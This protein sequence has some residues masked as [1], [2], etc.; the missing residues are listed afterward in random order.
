MTDTSTQGNLATTQRDR[1]MGEQA[2]M[3]AMHTRRLQCQESLEF[4]MTKIEKTYWGKYEEYLGIV[5]RSLM[6]PMPRNPLP[7]ETISESRRQLKM[8]L[9]GEFMKMMDAARTTTEKEILQ[10]CMDAV[11]EGLRMHQDMTGIF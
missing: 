5:E 3:A 2:F 9:M 10:G 7:V 6:S 11:E 1:M 4:A 8:N